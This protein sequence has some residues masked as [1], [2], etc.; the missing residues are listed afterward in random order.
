V[1]WIRDAR[2]SDLT[3]TVVVPTG[4]TAHVEVPLVTDPSITT[5]SGFALRSAIDVEVVVNGGPCKLRCLAAGTLELGS[6][7]YPAECERLLSHVACMERLDRE[8]VSLSY[9]SL[10]H[11][12]LLHVSLSHMSCSTP[13]TP[14]PVLFLLM[15]MRGLKRWFDRFK[16]VCCKEPLRFGC[17]KRRTQS[18][19]DLRVVQKQQHFLSHPA[20]EHPSPQLNIPPRCRT[21]H[22]AMKHPT[23]LWNITLRYGTSHLA[24]KHPTLP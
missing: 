20:M 9:M 17:L 1:S 15:T 6:A 13:F 22:P 7:S 16:R 12:S 11:V 21:S 3:L 5:I 24:V 19:E 4:A 14:P 8:H 10:S 18:W 23:L 2:T